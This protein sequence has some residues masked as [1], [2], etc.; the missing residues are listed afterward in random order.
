M[1]LVLPRLA[2]FTMEHRHKPLLVLLSLSVVCLQAF[3]KAWPETDFAAFGFEHLGSKLALKKL[4]AVQKITVISWF[5][6]SHF[7]QP[8]LYIFGACLYMSCFPRADTSNSA[9]APLGI[10]QKHE[11]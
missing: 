10:L 7:F 9:M 11:R 1:K 6:F 2:C 5:H 4:I 3:A 8:V